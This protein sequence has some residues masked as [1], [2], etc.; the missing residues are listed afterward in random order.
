MATLTPRNGC[1]YLHPAEVV[2]RVEKTFAYVEATRTKSRIRSDP[3][4][5]RP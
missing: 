5:A 1:R 2:R 4:A 3:L